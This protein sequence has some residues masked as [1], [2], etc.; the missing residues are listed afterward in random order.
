MKII[1]IE[2]N[3]IGMQKINR[4]GYLRCFI[5]PPNFH[6]LRSWY[7]Y[8]RNTRELAGTITLKSKETKEQ[9]L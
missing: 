7:V 5:A 3:G 2:D 4:E 9:S 8:K 6:W 1:T